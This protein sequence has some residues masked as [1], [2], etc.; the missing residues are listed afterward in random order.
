MKPGDRLTFTL[1][2][3]GT[4]LV[5]VKRKSIL[6]LA[7]MLHKPGRKAVPIDQMKR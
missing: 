5:R 1:M 3:D 6:S 4:L 7:G 2:P